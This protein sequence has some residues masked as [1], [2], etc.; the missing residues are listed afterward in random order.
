MAMG[1]SR[2]QFEVR[3]AIFRA[4]DNV[5]SSRS[6]CFGDDVEKHVEFRKSGSGAPVAAKPRTQT[7][8]CSLPACRPRGSQE[9]GTEGKLAPA[10]SGGAGKASLN[11]SS[12]GAVRVDTDRPPGAA[13]VFRTGTTTTYLGVN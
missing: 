6:P 8:H 5:G 10:C 12:G 9:A 4:R 3:G 1:D 7:V 2:V 11:A 13:R